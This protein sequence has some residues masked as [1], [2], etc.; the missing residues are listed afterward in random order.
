MPPANFFTADVIF[1]RLV[2]QSYKGHTSKYLLH[3][4]T[5]LVLTEFYPA[6]WALAVDGGAFGHMTPNARNR[7]VA[8]VV[9]HDVD[10]IPSDLN[11]SQPTT[12]LT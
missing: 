3:S 12:S 2:C 7:C 10:G 1:S 6:P 5:L 11:A 9:G 4:R 8:Y